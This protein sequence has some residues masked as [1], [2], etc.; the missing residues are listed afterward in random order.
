MDWEDDD[1]KTTLWDKGAHE[2]AARDLLRSAP[3]PPL[4]AAG[5]PAFPSAGSVKALA[6]GSGGAA[7]ALPRPGPLPPLSAP[8]QPALPQITPLPAAGGG[9]GL[10]GVIVV[11]AVAL[12]AVAVYLFL[13]PAGGTLV[14]TVTGPN[15]ETVE[16]VQVFVDEE[17]ACTS[18][19]CR[20]EGLDTGTHIV[21]V[22]ADGYKRTADKAINVE[23]GQNV[24]LPVALVKKSQGTGIRVGALGTGLRL[25]IDDRDEG[26]L[27]IELK[28]MQPGEYTVRISG[29]DRYEPFE[30]K[31]QVKAGQVTNLEPKLKV[32]KGLAHIKPGTGADGAKVLL[33]SGSERRPLP[34]LPIKIDIKPEKPYTLV[35]QKN[36]YQEYRK[37]IS[38]EDGKAEK[39]F[40]IVLTPQ[41]PPPSVEV[42]PV[43]A[44]PVA[45]KQP[46]RRRTT[47]RP[48]VKKPTRVVKR[49]PAP[50]KPAAGEGGRLNIN[51]VPASGVIL[52]G[53][54]L[55]Q[56]PKIG[57]AV[58]PGLHT[59]MFVHP[60]LGRKVQTVTV[61]PG[62]T[63]TAAVRFQ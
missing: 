42:A 5:M 37:R 55:G 9:K 24:V 23:K 54:P 26:P 63:A 29:S 22:L 13:T 28:Q 14:V 58:S 12:A 10:V 47:S 60:E 30:Q 51:S 49:E 6:S 8:P 16:N 43:A 35:A 15:D 31:V 1:E 61:K 56:T 19:T 7:P 50:P 18:A 46:V 57:V 53:R 39:V 38:F 21:S 62:G 32:I 34:K 25:S 36:G 59:V 41:R 17:V 27:P 44:K 20:V 40:E 11:A 45:R 33:V 52:D 48:V 4:P 3:P 2:D